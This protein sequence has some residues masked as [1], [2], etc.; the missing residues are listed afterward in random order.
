MLKQ[1]IRATEGRVVLV[2]LAGVLIGGSGVIDYL[3]W[4][5]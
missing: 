2:I 4:N 1:M 5:R 3:P